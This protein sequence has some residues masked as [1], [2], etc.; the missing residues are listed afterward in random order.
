[1]SIFV[2]VVLDCESFHI[3]EGDFSFVVSIKDTLVAGNIGGCWVEFFVH[4]SVE[5][6]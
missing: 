2:A 4:G 3:V 1:M 6:H 5:V